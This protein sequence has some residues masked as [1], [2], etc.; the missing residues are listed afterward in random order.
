MEESNDSAHRESLSAGKSNLGSVDTR[1][2]HH[3]LVASLD[4]SA[5]FHSESI[6]NKRKFEILRC[7]GLRDKVSAVR[8]WWVEISSCVFALLTM[9]AIV[10]TLY[11]HQGKPLPQWPYHLSVNTLL[12]I[13]TAVLKG[14]II[15]VVSECIGQFKWKWF[16]QERPLIDLNIYD[17][18]TRG[19]LG[20]LKILWLLRLRDGLSSTGA[21]VAILV[22]TVDPFTQQLVRYYSCSVPAP[23]KQALVPR[24]S[25]FGPNPGQ[26]GAE[27]DAYDAWFWPAL[28]DAFRGGVENPEGVVDIT[29]STGNCSFSE[30][31]STVGFCSQCTDVTEKLKFH[32]VTMPISFANLTNHE[33][34]VLNIEIGVESNETMTL[35]PLANN[36]SFITTSL[37]SGFSISN[38]PG[39]NFN[40]TG[41][42]YFGYPDSPRIEIIVAKQECLFSPSTGEAPLMC[43]LKTEAQTW[44]CQGYGAASCILNSC[45][46]T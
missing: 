34:S 10:A 22:L 5:A 24:T 13:Y 19:P 39:T 42:K 27:I 38:N 40:F 25:L 31:Y 8:L 44:R 15:T 14:S 41:S 23:G 43:D 4:P 12:S 26:S 9:I 28:E 46:R 37:P 35:T 29:C 32:T 3:G 30:A 16:R 6:S 36:S 21:L 17:E 45:V 33:E 11:P 2:G 1:A 20:A 18:A 7:H